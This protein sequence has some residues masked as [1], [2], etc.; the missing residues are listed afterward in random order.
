[1]SVKDAL[2]LSA[3]TG[4]G[5]DTL[6]KRILSLAGPEEGNCAIVTNQRHLH[7]MED[8]LSALKDAARAPE[9]DLAATDLHNALHA[10][11]SITGTD[12]DEQVIDKIFANFCVGK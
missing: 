6:K 2:R 10:L 12:V 9:L 1:M 8:A 5:L 3:K 4:A 11:G 7:A